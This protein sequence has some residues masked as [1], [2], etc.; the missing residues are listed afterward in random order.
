MLA[1][2]ARGAAELST[3]EVHDTRR[4]AASH[5]WP[6]VASLA[7]LAYAAANVLHEGLGHGGACL[8]VGG[9]PQLLTTANFE[10]GTDGLLPAASRLIAASGT[11]ANLIGGAAAVIAYRRS[12]AR[13]PAVRFF[14]WLF[15]TI[16]GFTA[17]G[18]FLFSGVGGIGDWAD[19]MAAV[20]PQWVWRPPLAAAGFALYWLA[21]QRA[22]AAL[23]RFIGG[24]PSD[25]FI[26]GR[27]MAVLSYVSGGLLYCLAGALNPSGPRL[28]LISAAGASLGGTS[29]L[30][31]GTNFLRATAPQG[32]AAGPIG[33][34]RDA[35]LVAAA[36][37]AALVFVC[38]LGPGITL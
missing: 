15:A 14:L 8:L 25:R 27:R 18:Y 20:H 38:V 29:G 6:T 32:I 11:I 36:A 31:W 34:A 4:G 35:R 28:L 7:V 22:F 19:V 30:W 13:G 1:A 26:V 3:M 24:R 12:D 21:A 9:A 10:C 17:F 37:A 16:N 5:D 2:M 23:G 33:I